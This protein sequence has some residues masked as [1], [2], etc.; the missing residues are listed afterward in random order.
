[1][2]PDRLHSVNCNPKGVIIV[3]WWQLLIM[4]PDYTAVQE[5]KLWIQWFKHEFLAGHYAHLIRVKYFDHSE[6]TF[7]VPHQYCEDTLKV[8]WGCFF[9]KYNETCPLS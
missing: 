7:G 6:D 5:M 2:K 8:L 1:M 3:F 4:A 9:K